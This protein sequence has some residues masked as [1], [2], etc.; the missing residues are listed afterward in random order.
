MRP[1]PGPRR[2]FWSA[3]LVCELLAVGRVVE[4]SLYGLEL[5]ILTVACFVVGRWRN[6]PSL[7]RLAAGDPDAATAAD[8]PIL[9]VSA[10]DHSRVQKKGVQK[11]A[12][13]Q[14]L[15]CRS[16]MGRRRTAGR[17]DS[18]SRRPRPRKSRRAT[19]ASVGLSEICTVSST[20]LGAYSNACGSH[21][22]DLEHDVLRWSRRSDLRSE[23]ART[24][25]GNS[26]AS[27]CSK[28]LGSLA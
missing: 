19:S 26:P 18:A 24:T 20:C 6:C 1:T 2:S 25:R 14:T 21:E 17:A 16:H 13:P 23:A 9:R 22:A 8:A 7:R 12:V 10:S 11:C 27:V 5:D 28:V 15:A 4:V 3:V